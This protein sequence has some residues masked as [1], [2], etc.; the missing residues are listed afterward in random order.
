MKVAGETGEMV[1]P[2]T[3]DVQIL[4]TSN[5]DPVSIRSLGVFFFFFFFLLPF[6]LIE[7]NCMNMGKR[8]YNMLIEIFLFPFGPF[9]FQSKTG[10]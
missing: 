8:N 9:I 4:L 3:G 2:Q 5:E 7:E 10:F 6:R 1:E